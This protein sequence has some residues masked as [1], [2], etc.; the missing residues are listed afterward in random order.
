MEK[1]KTRRG[2]F[3]NLEDSNIIVEV[4]ELV[5]KF[6]SEKKRQIFL[7]RVAENMQN[8]LKY[9]NKIYKIVNDQRVYGV[10][11]EFKHNIYKNTY[12]NMLYK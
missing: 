9:E 3:I 7:K 12:N 4:D 2:V 11:N 8:V 6:S 10:V 5:F 1:L